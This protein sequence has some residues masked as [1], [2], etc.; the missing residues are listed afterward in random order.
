MAIFELLC[1]LTL[2]AYANFASKL[3]CKKFYALL[4]LVLFA[5]FDFYG[6]QTLGFN[7]WNVL[8]TCFFNGLSRLY[9]KPFFDK[10]TIGALAKA[11]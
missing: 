11:V 6:K 3:K 10:I 2:L 4:N 1:I 5:I 9:K 7:Q 8:V